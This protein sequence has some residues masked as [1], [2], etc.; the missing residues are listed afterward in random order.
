METSIVI[1]IL[2]SLVIFLIVLLRKQFL[3]NE[4]LL[5]K[6]IEHEN[7]IQNVDTIVEEIGK[8]LDVLDHKGSFSSDDE[9]GWFFNDIKNLYSI[10]KDYKNLDI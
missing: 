1:I 7:I 5:D 10:L 4:L 8:K 9:I 2:T 3:L 6:S